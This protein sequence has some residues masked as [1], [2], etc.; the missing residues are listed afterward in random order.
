MVT[1]SQIL[2]KLQEFWANQGCNIV[3][4]YDIPAGA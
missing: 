2:L 3:Q 4:S 1:F